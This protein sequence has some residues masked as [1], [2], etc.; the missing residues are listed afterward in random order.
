VASPD[1]SLRWIET[2]DAC[3][4]VALRATFASGDDVRDVALPV[5]PPLGLRCAGS[6]GAPARAVPIA[7]G[8]GGLEAIVEGY[9]VLVNPDAGRA[10]LLAVPLDSPVVRGAPRSPDGQTLVVATSA[11]LVVRSAA[12]VRLLRSADLDGSWSEERDCAASNDGTHVA[13]VR[14]GKAWV[15]AWD[16]P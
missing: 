3:D 11:G 4:G 8:P 15:G 9:P 12:R 16:V 2:Y 5:A 7:W 6:R 10:A 1:G 14:A 13:C